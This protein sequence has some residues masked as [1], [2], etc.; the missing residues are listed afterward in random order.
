MNRDLILKQFSAGSCYSYILGSQSE[1]FIIDPHISLL[2][3]YTKYLAANKLNLKCIIDTHTHADH[4]SLAAVLRKRFNIPILMNEKAVSEVADRRLKDN[5]SISVGLKQ[6]DIL[7][8]PGHTDDAISIYGAGSL[9][10]GD[11]L[12]INS[13]GRTDFQNGSPESMFDTLQRLKGLPDG[14]TLFP[15]HDYNEKRRSTLAREKANNP[16]MK[17]TDKKAFVENARSKKLPKPFSIDNIIRVNR[18]GEAASLEMIMPQEAQKKASADPKVRF[19]DVRSPLEYSEVHIKDSINVPIDMLASKIKELSQQDQS[20]IVL[21]RTGSRSPVAADMLLQS[22]IG[23]V[24]VM[25]GGITA[26]QK[27]RLDVI[28]GESVM[29]LE[30]QVRLIAGI[31]MLAGIILAW[32]THPAFI[33]ISA[34]VAFGLIFAGLTNNCLMSMLLMKLPYNKRQYK[35]KLGG[36]TCS[37]SQ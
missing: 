34:W 6:F 16:F 30:R 2:G 5:D 4:F 7:Y 29:S 28:K 21:C 32:L 26:W 1:A 18:K 33:L 24:K 10:T 20:Y 37:I 23:S 25:E 15:G 27:A 3:E 22:G 9:F 8:T 11:V 17:E 36:G 12:L 19:L 35:T 13:V 14:T 31:L